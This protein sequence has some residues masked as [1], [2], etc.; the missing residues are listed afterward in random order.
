[1]KQRMFRYMLLASLSMIVLTAA[2]VLGVLY[3]HSY[4]QMQLQVRRDAMLVRAGVQTA[5]QDFLDHLPKQEVR[6]SLLDASGKVCYDSAADNM[7]ME[8]HLQR[9]EILAIVNGAAYGADTRISETLGEQTFYYALPVDGD[10][11]I[12]AAVETQSAFGVMRSILPAM[13]GIIALTAVLAYMLARRLTAMLL[14]PLSAVDFQKPEQNPHAYEELMPFLSRMAKQNQA[15]DRQVTRLKSQQEKFRVL[16]ENMS[17]GL[18][19]LDQN[20][21]IM[22]INHSAL[23]QLGGVEGREYSG[24]HFLQLSRELVVQKLIENALKGVRG[25][26]II[27]REGRNYEFYANPVRVDDQSRGVLLLSLD[28]TEREQAEKMRQEF[29]ANVSHELR[30]PLTSISGYAEMLAGDMVKPQDIRPFAQRIYDEACRLLALIEDIM[31]LS[32]LDEQLPFEGFAITDLHEIAQQ[33]AQRLSLA[34]SKQGVQIEVKGEDARLYGIP[35]Q[36]MELVWNLAENAVKYN[37][38]GGTVQIETR[39]MPQEV[40]LTVQDTGIGIPQDMQ[41]R[42]FERFFRVDKS[43]SKETGGTGLGLSIVKH[44]ALRYQ[45]KLQLE[46]AEQKGTK[47]TVR[48]PL[49]PAKNT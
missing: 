22:T 48:F 40:I 27:T 46:S 36:L 42:V 35:S 13:L 6:I 15:M 5:G 7:Q 26:Q 10:K 3:A 33:V 30:T 32:R 45:A 28:V 4:Q 19:L 34:A 49:L 38:E 41:A 16:A 14:Q 29:S 9:P 1:M 12:R 44:I 21:A 31:K 18:L 17:E 11:I 23:Q 37:H 47:I 24:R 2:L 8:N 43:R 39:Q 25:S 20:A